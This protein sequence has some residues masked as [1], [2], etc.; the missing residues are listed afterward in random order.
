MSVSVKIDGGRELERQLR[1]LGDLRAV[2]RAGRAALRKGG[3]PMLETAR[4]LAPD[5]PATGP[6]KF[7]RQSIK[8]A[9]GRRERGE[10]GDQV[11]VVIGIDQNVDPARYISRKSGQ[12]TYRDPGVAGVSVIIEFGRPGVPA[13][14]FMRPAFDQH[15]QGAILLTARSLGPE[16]ER[17]AAKLAKRAK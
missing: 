9:T 11:Y 15:A 5:D 10:D 13:Q 17:E 4:M 12:G 16:I 1:Q 7:L 8:M 3:K 14:P 6:G 2:R